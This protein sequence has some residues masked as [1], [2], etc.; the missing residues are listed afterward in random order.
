MP[1]SAVAGDVRPESSNTS[2]RAIMPGCPLQAGN[3]LACDDRA[4]DY[5]NDLVSRKNWYMPPQVS[6]SRPRSSPVARKPLYSPGC[7]Q[8]CDLKRTAGLHQEHLTCLNTRRSSALAVTAGFA[9]MRA[10][11]GLYSNHQWCLIQQG[12]LFPQG[13]YV[14]LPVA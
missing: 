8:M 3:L 7:L 9:S 12:G 1:A 2:N 4:E 10:T 5:R 14:L 11:S 6:C 13:K